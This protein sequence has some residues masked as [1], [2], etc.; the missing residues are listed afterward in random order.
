MQLD[1]RELSQEGKAI[2]EA[3]RDPIGKSMALGVVGAILGGVA[4]WFIYGW[5]Y[6]QGFYALALP[7]AAVGLGFAGLARRPMIAGGILCAI[8]AFFL[9][10]ACEWN[11][12]PFSDDGSFLY[13]LTHIH[14]VDS[15]MTLVLIGLGVA[16]AFWFGKGR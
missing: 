15:Q 14:K 5:A 11:H 1:E 13:F 9:M 4:G 7:G 16:L 8:A 12:S 2:L 6:S 10:A 3:S